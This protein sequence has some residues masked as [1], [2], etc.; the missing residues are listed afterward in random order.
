MRDRIRLITSGLGMLLFALGGFWA[1]A[2]ESLFAP[3]RNVRLLERSETEWI[4][5]GDALA[6]VMAGCQLL[7][8][9]NIPFLITDHARK[10]EYIISHATVWQK[11]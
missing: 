11:P 2:G 7:H 4:E 8:E 9:E 1:V 5:G 10:Y 3:S 6:K